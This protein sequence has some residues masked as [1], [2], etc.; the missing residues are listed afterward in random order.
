[1]G[2][3]SQWAQT[4]RGDEARR[5]Y[6]IYRRSNWAALRAEASGVFRNPVTEAEADAILRRPAGRCVYIHTLLVESNELAAAPTRC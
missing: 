3:P 4:L 5:W 2:V 6:A 1:M